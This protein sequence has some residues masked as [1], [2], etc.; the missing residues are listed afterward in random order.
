VVGRLAWIQ[1]TAGTREAAVSEEEAVF[2]IIDTM[3][4]ELLSEWE[5]DWIED[6]YNPAGITLD[7]IT[8]MTILG[9]CGC[10]LIEIPFEISVWSL[11]TSVLAL[12]VSK[13]I[14]VLMGAA[15]IARMRVPRAIF[16]L[17]CALSVLAIVPA[18]PLEYTQSVVIAAMSTV[19]C[20]LKATCLGALCLSSFQKGLRKRRAGMADRGTT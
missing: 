13:F 1:Q 8:K 20:F 17:G 14:I 9:V 19:E 7:R 18:L 6:H 4:P 11:N 3:E 10:S 12:V 16:A 15:A 5:R 2:S